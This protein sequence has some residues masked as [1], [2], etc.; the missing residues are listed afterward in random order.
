[1]FPH[2]AFHIGVLDEFS[3]Q[4]VN[5]IPKIM[6]VQEISVNDWASHKGACEAILENVE[7]DDII[8]SHDEACFYIT[9]CTNKQ[10]F[11]YWSYENLQE[12]HQTP[13]HSGHVI[14]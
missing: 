14:V 8:I 11:H 7:H 9:G 4:I 3:I 1:M 13:F 12:F 5:F 2:W 6:L 10:N